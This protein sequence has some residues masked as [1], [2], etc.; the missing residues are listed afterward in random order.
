[1]NRKQN[2]IPPPKASLPVAVRAIGNSRGVVIPKVILEQ[3]GIEAEM[4][5]TVEDA[6]IILS[7]PKKPVRQSWANDAK[8]I[9]N[10]GEDKLIAGDFNNENDGDWVW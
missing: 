9:A 6:K 1:M 10:A 3:L 4:D 5:M 2:P 7:K 8:A